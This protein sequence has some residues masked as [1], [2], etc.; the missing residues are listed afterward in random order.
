MDTMTA[1]KTEH[2]SDRLRAEIALL[3]AQHGKVTR[4]VFWYPVITAIAM[5]TTVAGATVG[6]VKL[7][8]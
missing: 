6:L 3:R 5:I 2:E 8:T 7:L 1:V 4:E